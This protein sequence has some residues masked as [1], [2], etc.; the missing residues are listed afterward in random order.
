[1]DILIILIAIYCSGYYYATTAAGSSFSTIL[2]GLGIVILF[3]RMI[4]IKKNESEATVLVSRGKLA[5][6]CYLIAV[7]LITGIFRTGFSGVA[8]KQILITILAL[9]IT[10]VYSWDEFRQ[11][12]VKAMVVISVLSLA[13]LII[14]QT[15]LA[16]RFPTI[17]NYN[18]QTF[19]S[20]IFFSGLKYTY[21][22]LTNRL[23]GLFWEPGLFASYL[24]L[25]MIL[26]KTENKREYWLTQILFI[27]CLVLSRSGA[28]IAMI[29]MIFI[30]IIADK[31]EEKLSGKARIILTGLAV[32]LFILAQYGSGIIEVWINSNFTMKVL[33]VTNI[34]NYTRINA[35][36]V[37]LEIAQENLPFGIGIGGYADEVARYSSAMASS[38]TS[39][40]TTYLAEY[41]I[42][43]VP[44][45]FFWIRSIFRLSGRKGFLSIIATAVLMLSILTKEPHGNLLFMNC[46]FMYKAIEDDARREQEED[47]DSE[48]TIQETEPGI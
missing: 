42:L 35:V 28:G 19:L 11:A 39:T 37:D 25:A 32:L 7:I 17:V 22:G 23:Q 41:G 20:G 18:N 10:G 30:T 5:L 31:S 44:I 2:L 14:I 34:S 12:F 24:S 1:M 4:R 27:V 43:G 9:L 33:N 21:T 15:P 36:L 47:I 46:I 26:L 38:G 3:C 48:T 29:P 8:T 45:I 40:F 13:G 6:A 16:N